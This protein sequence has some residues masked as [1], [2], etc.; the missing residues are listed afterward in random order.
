MLPMKAIRSLLARAALGIAAL[1]PMMSAQA[2]YPERAITLVAPFPAG[3][4]ADVVSRLLARKLEEQLGK[5]VVVE[6]RPGAGSVVGGTYVANAKPDGY[7]LLLG[8]NS[9]FTLNPAL[10]PKMPY[11]AATAFEPIGQV[12]TVTLALIVNPSVPA[13]TVAELVAEIKAHPDKY[14]YGSYGNGTTSNFAGAMF[15]DATGL[16]L[17][18]VPYRGSS[19]AMADLIGGQIPVAFDTIVASLPQ[20]RNGKIR[21]LAVTSVKRSPFMPEVPSLDEL[22]YKGYEMTSYLTIVAPAGLPADVR[23][24]LVDAMTKLMADPDTQ[25]K[26][27]AAGFEADWKIIPDWA[28]SVGAEIAAMKAIARKSNIRAD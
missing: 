2:V 4:S 12:G 22:G 18:H 5:T 23:K 21:A 16:N 28:G 11:D 8:S 13:Q 6:N 25:E 14:V 1:I 15:N 3:G 10:L 24:R 17:L 7:T 26:M 20:V 19:P 27:K 9:T